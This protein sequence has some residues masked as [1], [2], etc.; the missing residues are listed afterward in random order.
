MVSEGRLQKVRQVMA[1]EGLDV[2]LVSDPTN[3][4]YFSGYW[5]ILPGVG[6]IVQREM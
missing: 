6:L 4:R 2:I 3:V 1:A 5:S